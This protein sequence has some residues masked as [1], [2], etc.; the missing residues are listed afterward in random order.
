MKIFCAA[1]ALSLTSL[2]GAMACATELSISPTIEAPTIVLPEITT[3]VR[4]SSSDINRLVCQEE[5]KDVV[6]S[7]EKG[8]IVKLSGKNAF[9]K[10]VLVKKGEKVMYSETPTEMFI[11]CGDTIFNLIAMP[12]RLPAQTIQLATGQKDRVQKNLSLFNGLPFEQ[13]IL[14][15]IKESYTE[16]FPE[17]Y[18]VKKIGKKT[19]FSFKEIELQ[20]LREIEVEGEGIRIRECEAALKSPLPEFLLN[21]RMFLHSGLTENP[22]AV[23]IEEPLLKKG[24]TTRIFI[25]EVK[26]ASAGDDWMMPANPLVL[27]EPP[28]GNGSIPNEAPETN[29]EGVN[30]GGM[31]P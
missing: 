20:I 18:V 26:P 9:I 1:L 5:I 15:V 19:K 6:T 17:S 31:K 14:R 13:K 8:V 29:S 16:E 23:A 4:L 27:T 10:F 25:V 22:V 7:K 30:E 21:E 11:V 24:K 3:R 28:G 12:G 2:H